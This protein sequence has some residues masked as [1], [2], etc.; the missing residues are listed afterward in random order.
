M[1]KILDRIERA[2]ERPPRYSPNWPLLDGE[3]SRPRINP[4]L[5]CV[6]FNLTPE[7]RI[8]IYQAVLTDPSQFLHIVLNKYSSYPDERP[9]KLRKARSVAHYWCE[10]LESPFPTWQ[11]SCYG[12]SIHLTATANGFVYRPVTETEDRLLALLLSC[13]RVYSEAL[14]ILYRDNIFHFRGSYSLLTFRHTLSDVQ[15]AALRHVHISAHFRESCRL[16]PLTT[17]WLPEFLPNWQE[18]CQHLTLPNLRS[19]RLD[20]VTE[21][22]RADDNYRIEPLRA[23]V[24]SRS[25]N[26]M[27]ACSR[28]R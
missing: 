8:M 18:C 9:R 28:L 26:W 17:E 24:L 25:R 7:L 27:P 12:E 22:P 14:H 11:H 16:P 5:D 20:L 2:L 6:L 23:E 10:D 13:R 19:L 4:Q 3:A 15:W 21:A 1:W